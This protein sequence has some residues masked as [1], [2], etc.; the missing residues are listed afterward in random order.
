MSFFIAK[1]KYTKLVDGEEKLVNE[2]YLTNGASVADCEADVINELSAQGRDLL[3]KAVSKTPIVEVL[4][5]GDVLDA[6]CYYLAKVAL[7]TIDEKTAKEKKT[8][9]QWL[10]AATDYNDA[11]EIVLREIHKSMADIEIVSLAKS[12]IVGIVTL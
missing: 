4:E 12:S 1:V 6:D 9:S 11:Y 2:Q 3:V 10:I 7:I 5:E 8:I